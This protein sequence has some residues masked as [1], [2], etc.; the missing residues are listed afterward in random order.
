MSGSRQLDLLAIGDADVD[1]YIRGPR[2]EPGQKVLGDLL[3]V[4]AGGMSANVACAAARLGL[5]AG[6]AAPL[7][8]DAFASTAL[9]YYGQVGLDTSYVRQVAGARTYLSVVLLDEHGEKSLTVARTGAFFPTLEHVKCI[10]FR[11]VRAVQIAPFAEAEA[12]WAARAARDAGCLVAMDIEAHML[13]AITD[14]DA[15]VAPVDV[16]F[17]NEF[18][19]AALGG[20]AS[21]GLDRLRSLGP[22][23]VVMTAGARGAVVAAGPHVET[24]AAMPADVVD[25]TGAGDCFSAGFLAAYLDGA[26]AVDCAQLGAVTAAFAVG[27][28]GGSHGVPDRS[29]VVA[30]QPDRSKR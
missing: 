14:L 27:A 2:A 15:L 8:D 4:T 28:I 12:R 1:L 30:A 16:V 17:V 11:A 26:H 5:R 22:T 24:V 9:A 3:D 6:L 21:G 19:A 7:G 25:T 23:V 13:D 20:T 10:D 18:A 29:A